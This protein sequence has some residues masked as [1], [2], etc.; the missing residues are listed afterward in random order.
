MLSGFNDRE[1]RMN[2][3]KTLF[4]QVPSSNFLIWVLSEGCE[5]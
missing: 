5:R 2:V 1:C 3:G 4:A